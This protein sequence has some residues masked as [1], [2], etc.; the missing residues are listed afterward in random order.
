MGL[1]FVMLIAWVFEVTP[2]GEIVWKYYAHLK[3]QTRRTPI[4]RMPRIVDVEKYSRLHS[5]WNN[6]QKRLE[7]QR[8]QAKVEEP[9]DGE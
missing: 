6:Y 4:Y 2:E 1:P 5:E 9:A 7:E 3:N 8:R